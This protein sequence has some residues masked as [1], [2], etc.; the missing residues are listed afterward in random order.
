MSMHHFKMRNGNQS[1]EEQDHFQ[2]NEALRERF[3]LQLALAAS[4][5][6]ILFMCVEYLKKKGMY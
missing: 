2:A 6:F 3:S 5:V 4:A 1:L